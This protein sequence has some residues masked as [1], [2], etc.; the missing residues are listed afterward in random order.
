MISVVSYLD[1]EDSSTL[2]RFHALEQQ[3]IGTN[4]KYIDLIWQIRSSDRET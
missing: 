1:L 4:S 2:T 3:N